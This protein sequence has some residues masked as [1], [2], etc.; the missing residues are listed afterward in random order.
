M[1][2]LTAMMNLLPHLRAEDRAKALYHGLSSV[3]SEANGASPRFMVRPLPGSAPDFP[4]LKRWFREFVEVRDSEGT[5]RCIVTAVMSGAGPGEMT[6]F[7]FAAATDHRYIETGHTA[8]FSNKAL[9][10]LDLAGWEMAAPILSSLAGSFASASRMEESN[11]WRNPVDLIAI[12]EQAF[13][14]LPET[15]AQGRD[16][17]ASGSPVVVDRGELL[18]VLLGDDAQ[19]I[20]SALLQALGQ[21]MVLE[22]LA[23]IVVYAAAL[24]I[25]RFHTR[26]EFSDWDSALHSF[27]FANAIHQAVRRAATAELARGIFDGAMT[28]YLNRFLNVPRTQR[29][30]PQRVLVES[31]EL[32]RRLPG[33]F[34]RQQNIH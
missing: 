26:N 13:G 17:R 8:D 18:K 6:D 27:S 12:L 30:E 1:T 20:A 11:S 33:L 19:A 34:D 25:A 4:T 22:E 16:R 21:G 2:T 7:L 10:A 9:E 29:P 23:G 14:R 32:L 28:V 31:D 5:E 24:R 15:L 3:S